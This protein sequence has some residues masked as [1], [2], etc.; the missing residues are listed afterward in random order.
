MKSISDQNLLISTFAI[1]ALAISWITAQNLQTNV[2]GRNSRL[3]W[4]R[5]LAV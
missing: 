1:G 3:L 4:Q 5:W 2:A